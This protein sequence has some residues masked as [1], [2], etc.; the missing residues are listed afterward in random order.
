MADA[1]KMD[2]T[3][4]TI[5]F[6]AENTDAGIRLDVFLQGRLGLTRNAVQKLINGNFTLVNDKAEKAGYKLR[7]CDIVSAIV[8][9]AVQTD[10]LP[11]SLPLDIVYED[12][13]LVVVNKQKGMVVHPASGH[14]SGTLVNALLHHC[15][16]SLS[17]INGIM[18]PGIVHRIDKDTSGLLVCAK[19]DAAHNGLAA[20]F[21]SHNIKREYKAVVHG[22]PAKDTGKIDAPIARHAKHRKKM[23]IMP[24]GKRAV[25]NYEVLERYGKYSLIKCTLETGRTHQ[26]RVHM[27]SI[28]HPVLG[29]V[30]YGSEKQ[31]FNTCGQ[32][33]HAGVLGFKHPINA[34]Y[35]EF[36]ST[37]PDYFEKILNVIK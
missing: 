17:G 34:E 7:A 28:G 26:I 21:A 1:K 33:L 35:L 20:Q 11:E 30:V 13:D 5:I 19:N 29:D 36:N 25:T 14:Y 15:K 6:S 24:G 10:I 22:K 9:A 31:P 32:V 2:S 16:D 4:K 3:E 8:P 27:A 37:L 18:R 23:A 12:S